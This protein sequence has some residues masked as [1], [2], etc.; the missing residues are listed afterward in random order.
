M[1]KVNKEEMLTLHF[2][3][4]EFQC[5][6]CRKLEINEDFIT[7]LECARV[8]AR[9]PFVIAS[10]YRCKKHNAKV[11]GVLDSA[12]T[13]GCAADIQVITERERFR[14]IYGLIW[15]QFNRIGI[16]KDF[17]HV[18]SDKIKRKDVMWTNI[19]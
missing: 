11:G 15:A 3:K 1:E 19:T 16:Y 5:P 13:F 10:G 8:F 9:I 14:I 7:R 12:H 18:D 2:S 17:I 4:K 6:C